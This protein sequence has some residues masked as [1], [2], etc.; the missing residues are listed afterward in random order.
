MFILS[1]QYTWGRYTC[2]CSSIKCPL[3]I[4]A[5]D[6]LVEGIKMC[7]SHDAIQAAFIGLQIMVFLCVT[8]CVT[9]LE[10]TETFLTSL[11]NDNASQYVATFKITEALL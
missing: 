6:Y 10:M 11:I 7:G 5:E 4:T 1:V 3:E 2:I 9:W 8:I